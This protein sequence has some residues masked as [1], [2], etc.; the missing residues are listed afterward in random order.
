[1][2]TTAGRVEVQF[3]SPQTQFGKEVEGTV[4]VDPGKLEVFMGRS[5]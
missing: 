1:L 3:A 5:Q 2:T 4:N